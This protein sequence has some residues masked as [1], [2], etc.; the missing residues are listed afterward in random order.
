MFVAVVPSLFAMQTH[1]E[2]PRH[3]PITHRRQGWNPPR[4]A[5]APVVDMPRSILG[6]TIA[7]S[8]GLAACTS[9]TS[10]PP[11]SPTVDDQAAA[12]EAGGDAPASAMGAAPMVAAANVAPAPNGIELPADYQEW[13]VLAVSHRKDND[14][15]RVILGN[16]VAMSAARDGNINPW[17]RGT[18][19]AK[20]V[21]K[22]TDSEDWPDATVPGEFVHAEFMFK[23]AD[24]YP[25]TGGWGFA[26]WLGTEQKPF[27]DDASFAQQCWDCHEPVDESDY[28]YTRPALMPR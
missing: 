27:G 1:N 3:L 24:A 10:T 26:R 21:W 17:P 20:M 28:V 2:A 7:A 14:S 23:D 12:M 6:L 9:G 25:Q 15:L 11:S 4:T 19:L 22:D 8:L 5:P 16:D 18:V 13:Q